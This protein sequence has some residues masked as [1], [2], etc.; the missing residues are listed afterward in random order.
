M[1]ARFRGNFNVFLKSFD[2]ESLNKMLNSVLVQIQ[3]KWERKITEVWLFALLPI[4]FNV[5]SFVK[6][7]SKTLCI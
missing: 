6:R 4:K 2:A 3:V 7:F 5:T 1:T